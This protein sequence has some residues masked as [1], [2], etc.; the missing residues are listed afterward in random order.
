M[1]PFILH[2]DFPNINMLPH[3]LILCVFSLYIYI[4]V[5]VCVC[6]CVCVFSEPFESEF[7]ILLSFKTRLLN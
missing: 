6:V 2:L 4:Y 7:Q 5:C 1:N 3:L